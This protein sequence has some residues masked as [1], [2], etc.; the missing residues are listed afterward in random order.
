MSSLGTNSL[1]QI[2]DTMTNSVSN[3][4]K[5]FI[6]FLIDNRIIQSGTSF[7]IA[8]QVNKLGSDFVDNIISPII[9]RIIDGPNQKLKEQKLEIA[10]I[11]F[12]LGNFFSSLLKFIIF[13]FVF[14]QIYKVLG[15]RKLLKK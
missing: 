13:M 1:I 15:F 7:I 14:H 11:K 5:E 2:K 10:G 4:M 12:E 6:D 9:N 8:L 3:T